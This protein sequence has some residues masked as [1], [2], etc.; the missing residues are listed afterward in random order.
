MI[1][2]VDY[3]FKCGP[4]LFFR[5]SCLTGYIIMYMA[6]LDFESVYAE[7]KG[8][9]WKLVSRYV[10]S[11]EDRE[12]LFQEVFLNVHKALPRFRG[13]SS[14]GTWL[15]RI[16]AN[17]AVNYLKQRDRHRQV[18]KVLSSLRII[19]TEEPP[20]TSETALEK[21]LARLNPR[22]RMIV[23]LADVEEKKLDEIS[24]LMG[25]PLGTVK[26]T[27]HRAREILK[28]ELIKHDQL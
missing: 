23:V 19:D 2:L 25:L 17:S 4:E 16:T 21:P 8:N 3:G 20:V 22:Q 7:H 14:V 12:D 9:V 27:L 13:E 26:S 10:F 5:R 1:P 18:V 15:Y 6:Q 24:E 28:K 11:R